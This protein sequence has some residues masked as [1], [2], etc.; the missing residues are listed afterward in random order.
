MGEKNPGELNVSILAHTC[1]SCCFD[2]E[3]L[4]DNIVLKIFNIILIFLGSWLSVYFNGDFKH[5]LPGNLA[6]FLC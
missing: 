1:F 6:S 5:R 2:W 3:I 4:A